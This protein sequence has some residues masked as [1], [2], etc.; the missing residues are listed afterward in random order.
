[1]QISGRNKITGV[2]DSVRRDD[3]AAQITIT[4]QGTNQ[5]VATITSDA[6]GELNL[7]SG[8][9]VQALIKASDVMVMK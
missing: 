7:K 4:V 1:M 6:A 5:L 9:K 2:I 3:V 8:D